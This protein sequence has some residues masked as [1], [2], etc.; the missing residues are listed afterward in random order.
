MDGI[1]IPRKDIISLS[2]SKNVS[3]LPINGVAKSQ[4]NAVFKF[5]K[6]TPSACAPVIIY[7]DGAQKYQKF[8]IYTRK[9]KNELVTISC[10]DKMIFLSQMF[11]YS[12]LTADKN[13]DVTASSVVQQIGAQCQFTN[14]GGYPSDLL[15]KIPLDHVSGTDCENILSELS[16]VYCGVWYS[17]TDGASETLRFNRFGAVTEAVYIDN[18]NHSDVEIGAAKGPISRIIA[19]N[20]SDT[21]DTFGSDDF[22]KILRLSGKYFTD[23]ITKSVLQAVKGA[24]YTGFTIESTDATTDAHICCGV[25]CG[26]VQYIATKI[27]VNITAG[28]II[29]GFSA[30]DLNEPEWDYT[31]ALNRKLKE[32]VG[33]NVPS[34]GTSITRTEGIK[35]DSDYAVITAADGKMSFYKKTGGTS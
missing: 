31:G 26:E 14:V 33:Y 7:V 6:F 16:Q 15:N 25:Y 29:T 21:F 35:I 13:G 10:V 9:I 28:G 2:I 24:L 1:K 11:D 30:A 19:T 27:A 22:T 4:L 18:V 5:E 3:G 12:A 32:K 17:E 34:A 8:Y 20:G 23:R